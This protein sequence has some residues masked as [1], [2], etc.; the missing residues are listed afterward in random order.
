M[1]YAIKAGKLIDGTGAE[2]LENVVVLVEK[3]RISRVGGGSE[4]Q[5]PEGYEVI[6]ASH[7]TLLP[8]FID[9]HVHVQGSGE[10]D[11]P[12][13]GRGGNALVSQPELV[14][15]ALKNVQKSLKAG[16][17]TLRNCSSPYR[18]DVDLRNAIDKGDFVG[19]RIWTSGYGLT[20]TCGH[21]DQDKKLA[22]HT[23]LD[24]ED[25]PCDSPDQAR[26]AVMKNLNKN[27]DFIKMNV[28]VGEY[29]FNYMAKNAPEMT[30]ETMK[31]LISWAHYHGRKVTGHG[32]DGLGIDFALEAG[33]DG[34]EHGS[35]LTDAQIEK[36]AK[37]GTVLCPTTS[38]LFNQEPYLEQDL[39]DDPRL[40]GWYKY[41]LDNVPD[42]VARA[43]KAGVR[44][45]AGCDTA[46]PYCK[47]GTNATEMAGLVRCGLTPMEAIV[48]ATGGA[49]DGIGIPDVGYIKE[50]KYADLVI[51]DGDPLE[52]ITKLQDQSLIT[53]VMKGGEIVED[54]R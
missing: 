4:V 25:D 1:S 52:D 48:A 27:V 15:R 9:A 43:R 36:M 42:T 39:K 20:S 16:F 33:I 40:L 21:M 46:M 18:I 45:I 23:H 11:D 10:P 31:M 30:L 14:L 5:I 35:F 12:V 22:Y 19:P 44:I 37:Q 41:S 54:K 2:P 53:L 8:G 24:M 32:H 26:V 34:I 13:F 28:T 17:T 49:A 7:K 3:D 29:N 47:H 38:V 51:F 50:G 6:D